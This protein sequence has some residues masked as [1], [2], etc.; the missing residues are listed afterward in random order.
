MMD[1][2]GQARQAKGQIEKVKARNN[3]HFFIC[4]ILEVEGA[5][6]YDLVDRRRIQCWAHIIE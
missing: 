2:R 5:R 3:T 1:I 4:A 6:G